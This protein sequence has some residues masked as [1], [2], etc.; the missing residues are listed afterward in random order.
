MKLDNA[1][2]AGL[3]RF[4]RVAVA[5]VVSGCIAVITKEQKFILLVPFLNAIAKYIRDE[6]KIDVKIL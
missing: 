6:Y 4:V 1:M 3:N 2:K 5:M